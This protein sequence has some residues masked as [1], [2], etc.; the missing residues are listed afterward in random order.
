MPLPH[1]CTPTSPTSRICRI[2]PP[3]CS[4][5]GVAVFGL[6]NCLNALWLVKL[7][8]MAAADSRK[9]RMGGCTSTSSGTATAAAR[10]GKH[11]TLVAAAAAAGKLAIAVNA[12]TTAAARAA[13]T[14]KLD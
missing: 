9:A 12:Y 3:T 1:P 7:V 11:A 8:G 4:P 13:A 6:L 14:S 2:P 10:G 5:A